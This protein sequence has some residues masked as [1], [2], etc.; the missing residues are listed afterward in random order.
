TG[1]ADGASL[2]TLDVLFFPGSDL[3]NRFSFPAGELFGNDF[4]GFFNIDVATDEDR[5]VVG[6]I[7]GVEV[8]LDI[9]QGRV[10]QVLRQ[11]DGRL[12]SI[13]VFLVQL[14]IESIAGDAVFVVQGAV[15]LLIDGFQFGMEKAE[16]R[17]HK[18]VGFNSG[19]LAQAV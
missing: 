18:T 8:F 13:R 10:L 3:R 4:D 14:I 2:Y 15:Q 11:A 9:D 16:Y 1:V 12:L 17:I 5:H 6:N 19:P 7:I